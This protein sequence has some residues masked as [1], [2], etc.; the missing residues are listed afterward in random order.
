MTIANAIK[1][2]IRG[3]RRADVD[4]MAGVTI[5]ADSRTA[6]SLIVVLD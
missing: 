4:I 2:R 5:E 6:V 3:N 1:D